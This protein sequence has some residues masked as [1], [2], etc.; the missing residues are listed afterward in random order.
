MATRKQ[1]SVLTADQQR[2]VRANMMNT[3]SKIATQLGEYVTKGK[4]V[5][6]GR[7]ILLTSERLAAYRLILDRTVPTL[8]ATEVTHKSG[9]EAM[10]QG[11]LVARLA[12]LARARPELAAKLQEAI[13]GRVIDGAG[14]SSG[15]ELVVSKPAEPA[16]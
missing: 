11:A 13:G 3:A 16:E 1:R 10:D 15:R 7:E 12:E 2:H 14:D 4:M 9:I 5:I 8:S 6:A